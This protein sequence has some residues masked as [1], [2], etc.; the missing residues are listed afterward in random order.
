MLNLFSKT[1]IKLP[2]MP[3][4]VY[5]HCLPGKCDQIISKAIISANPSEGSDYIVMAIY[6]VDYGLAFWRPGDLRWTVV[7][8]NFLLKDIIW[9]NGGFYVVGKHSQVCRVEYGLNN[10]LIEI[11]SHDNDYLYKKKI[12]VVDFLGD[13]LL[14]YRIMDLIVKTKDFYRTKRVVLFKLDQDENQFVELKSIDGHVL[15]LGSNHAMCIPTTMMDK[16]KDNTIYFSDDNIYT[17]YKY[18]FR[19]S[20][21]YSIRDESV[22]LFPLHN[23]Y[24]QAKQPIFIDVDP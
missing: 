8:S 4:D 2:Q 21:I 7:N 5:K 12:Y 13:L 16:T 17:S 10:K 19:D 20:G 23:I 1:Q 11:T 15:F 14:V 22:T 6:F 18:G 3:Y 9:H 24:Y